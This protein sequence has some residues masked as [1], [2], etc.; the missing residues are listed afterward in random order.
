VGSW[1]NVKA[2]ALTRARTLALTAVIGL[3]VISSSALRAADPAQ[4]VPPGPKEK[5]PVCGMFV[6]PY[7]Q[8][9]AEIVFADG[10]HA[11]FDGPKDLFKFSLDVGKYLH[12]KSAQDIAGV[13][14]TEYYSTELMSAKGL[15]F[16]AGSDVMGPMGAELVPVRGENE[17]QTFMRDHSGRKLLKFGDITGADIPR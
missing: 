10:T 13:F 9:T 11:V 6:A 16:V 3:A 12:G 8:W 17:A 5:C 15:F 4:S 1:E 2:M 7:P 14:V